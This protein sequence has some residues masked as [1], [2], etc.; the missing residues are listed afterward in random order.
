MPTHLRRVAD[1]N[2]APTERGTYRRIREYW[3]DYC[4][5]RGKPNTFWA[6]ICC[7]GCGVVGMLGSNH[8]VTDDGVVS[9]SDVCPYPPC[10]FH[11]FIVLDDWA[12]PSTARRRDAEDA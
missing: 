6:E 3:A 2:D 10:T 5:S 12:R 1:D 7:P 4:E 8:R 9:P 11:V